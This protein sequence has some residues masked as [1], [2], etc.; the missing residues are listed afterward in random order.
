M[1]H[2][3]QVDLNRLLHNDAGLGWTLGQNLLYQ[4]HAHEGG[5]D[6]FRPTGGGQDVNVAHSLLRPSEASCGGDVLEAFHSP[7]AG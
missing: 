2:Y 5:D 6:L 4:R 3:P 7:Q 1:L